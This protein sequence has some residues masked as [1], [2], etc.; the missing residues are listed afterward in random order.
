MGIIKKPPW[1]IPLG[2]VWRG[3]RA[4]FSGPPQVGQVGGSGIFLPIIHQAHVPNNSG[5]RGAMPKTIIF[6]APPTA[7]PM[8]PV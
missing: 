7:I 5:R 6:V 2:W 3:G 8:R 1:D 4:Y